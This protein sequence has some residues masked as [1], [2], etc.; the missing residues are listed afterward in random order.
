MKNLTIK[1]LKFIL[2]ISYVFTLSTILKEIIN[3]YG[4]SEKVEFSLIILLWIP[5]LFEWLRK[6]KVG[7]NR[8]K[9]EPYIY[10]PIIFIFFL[11]ATYIVT[12]I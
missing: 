2:E 6:L 4:L 3:S 11:I 1:V 8:P 9:F 7:D 5:L 10:L 12:I